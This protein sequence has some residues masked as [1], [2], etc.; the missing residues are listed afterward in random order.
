MKE[1][2]AKML[3]TAITVALGRPRGDPDDSNLEPAAYMAKVL[4]DEGFK[5]SGSSMQGIRGDNI[6]H[7]D[8]LKQ[9]E[10]ELGM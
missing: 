3:Q 9:I 4:I 5:V 10:E 2:S 7:I 8:F 6:Y 1:S